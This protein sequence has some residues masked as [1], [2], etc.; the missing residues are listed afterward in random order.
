MD[1]RIPLVFAVV[2]YIACAALFIYAFTTSD[3]QDFITLAGYVSSSTITVVTLIVAVLLLRST[4]SEE[5]RER[6]M[7]DEEEEGKE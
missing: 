3:D 6:Y 1:K 5:Y 7:K 2:V 4:P